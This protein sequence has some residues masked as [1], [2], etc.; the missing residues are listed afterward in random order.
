VSTSNVSEESVKTAHPAKVGSGG[1]HLAK[2]GPTATAVA[3][4]APDQ[5]LA[6]VD[7]AERSGSTLL[8]LLLAVLLLGA[9]FFSSYLEGDLRG[10]F[11]LWFLAALASIGIAA[12]FLYAIGLLHFA[13]RGNRND[14]TKQVADGFADGLIV[15]EGERRIVY[16]NAAYQMLAGAGG[17][18]ELRTVERLFTGAPEVSEAIYRLAQ[19][20]REGRRG[21]EEIRL[22]PALTGAAGAGWYRVRV[23]PLEEGAH[24]RTL[25]N[26]TDIT[27]E[28]ERHENVFQELQNAVDYL[29]HAPAG[30][31]SAEPSGAIVY[32][33]A[34]LANWLDYDIAQVGT[35]GL[36]LGD[37]VP[38]SGVALLAAGNGVP[39]T[40]KTEILD[41]DLKRRGGQTLPVRLFHRIAHASDG[42][43]GP[44]RTL[45]LNR[46]QGEDTAEG[47]RA[48]EVRFARFFN[49]SPL[50]IAT[51]NRSGGMVLTNAPFAKLFAGIFRTESAAGRNIL[52]TVGEKNRAELEALL[53]EAAAGK[54]DLAPLDVVLAGEGNRSARFIVSTVEHDGDGDG[55]AAVIYAIDTTEQRALQEQFAQANKMQAVGQLAGGVAHDFNNV[56]TAIIGYSD[57][58]LANHRPTDP[59]FQDIMQ[60]KQNANRAASLTRQLLA[61]SR[62]Q[63]LRPQVLQLTD[64]ISDLSMLL[65]RLLGEKIELDVKHGRDLWLVMADVNQFEQVVMNLAV[66]ARDAMAEGG[67]LSIRSQNV[68]PGEAR[69]LKPELSPADADWVMIEVAD[70]G[71]G[72][73]ADVLEKIFEPFFTTKEIGKGTGLGLSTV[74]GIVKQTGG[75]IYCD[76]VI[77]QGTSFRIFLPRHVPDPAVA[78]PKLEEKQAVTQDLTGQG[79]ILLV[80]DEEAVRAFG[81]RAL[82]SRGYTV[83]EAASG[84]EAMAA[85]EEVE[86]HLDL[87][88]SDVV[89]PEMDGPTL[90]GELRK[91][92]PDLKVIFVS[93]Y[94]EE[95]FKKN[96]PEG[97]QFAFLPKPF[98]LKQLVEAVKGMMD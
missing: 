97:A 22:V 54:S 61:F 78:V 77:G 20:A 59:S 82:R 48:A 24:R 42:T 14:I 32:M 92:Y 6:A 84:V 13:G 57:L 49:N 53:G 93:G 74:Y 50:A 83:L 15:T 18:A 79:T 63:T 1:R 52:A 71:S 23:A 36:T 30:F 47:Q 31:L 65:K 75:Y 38:G 66:N 10:Q 72:M 73:P 11:I 25:W 26:V 67:R 12:L 98:S 70:T 76:S 9:V 90:L 28:R 96:L 68:A 43:P 35:G 86:G 4:E 16:A 29:D 40:V 88:V 37:I 33:N 55:E 21:S 69:G 60:I 80:E 34:T 7:R 95:A 64:T 39:G 2:A 45:V 62:R 17:E 91:Q 89:M 5:P 41:L 56:L 8:V 58:L 19:T 27:R 44:S 3:G 85:I 46:S 87:V 51:V 81:A 94:A